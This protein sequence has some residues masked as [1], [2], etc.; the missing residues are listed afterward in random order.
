[1]ELSFNRDLLGNPIGGQMKSGI[2]WGRVEHLF[3]S[4][5]VAPDGLYVRDIL[6]AI[7]NTRQLCA[8][9]ERSDHTKHCR[10]SL[11]FHVSGLFLSDLL[12]VFETCSETVEMFSEF[13][14]NS[15]LRPKQCLFQ[16]S[17]QS[18]MQQ[19]SLGQQPFN[20]TMP[21]LLSHKWK[22]N[23][24]HTS[25][26]PYTILSSVPLHGKQEAPDLQITS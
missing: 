3:S 25:L 4:A 2:P 21:S 7:C 10:L 8:R 11:N 5:L 15:H 24:T 20:F 17:S 6:S 26:C 23:L 22:L 1:M 13:I 18:V 19:G 14:I 16:Q 12:A 9:S